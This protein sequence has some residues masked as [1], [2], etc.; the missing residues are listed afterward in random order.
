MEQEKQTEISEQEWIDGYNNQQAKNKKHIITS[1]EVNNKFLLIKHNKQMRKQ[2]IL[3]YSFNFHSLLDILTFTGEDVFVRGISNSDDKDC[4]LVIDKELF[5][6]M[7]HDFLK[8][9]QRYYENWNGEFCGVD[10]IWFTKYQAEGFCFLTDKENNSYKAKKYRIL[11]YKSE[12]EH[13]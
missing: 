8:D 3:D 12:M 4:V 10:S 13:G 6:R 2:K 1:E 5:M 7:F 9:K 11:E